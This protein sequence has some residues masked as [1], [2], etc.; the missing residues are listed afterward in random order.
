MSD[1]RPDTMIPPMHAIL[2]SEKRAWVPMWLWQTVKHLRCPG[3]P[4]YGYLGLHPVTTYQPFRWIFTRGAVL[5]AHVP[6]DIIDKANA[7]VMA[8]LEIGRA[9]V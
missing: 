2:V 7:E 8:E 1:L 4:P 5:I 3:W 9:H 6:Q